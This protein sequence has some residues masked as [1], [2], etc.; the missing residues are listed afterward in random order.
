VPDPSVRAPH[1]SQIVMGPL[2][3]R[4]S[5]STTPNW[6]WYYAWD[7]GAFWRV[8]PDGWLRAT[9]PVAGAWSEVELGAGWSAD[10]AA[11]PG[12]RSCEGRVVLRGIARGV[13]PAAGPVVARLPEGLRPAAAVRLP[14]GTDVGLALLEVAADGSVRFVGPAGGAAAVYLDAVGFA[15]AG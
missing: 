9:P 7:D 13:G 8:T 6:L 10:D 3:A 1:V 4:P 2:A 12:A 5:A 14:V 15:L 11:R